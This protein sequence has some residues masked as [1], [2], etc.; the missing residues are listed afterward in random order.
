MKSSAHLREKTIWKTKY[1]K[2][3]KVKQRQSEK[4][5]QHGKLTQLAVKNVSFCIRS[6]SI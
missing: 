1:S 4:R 6:G 3:L 5:F 2:W